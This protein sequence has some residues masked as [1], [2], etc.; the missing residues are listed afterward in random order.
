MT[1]QKELVQN[2]TPEVTKSKK[3]KMVAFLL[4]F[5]SSF[6]VGV[7]SDGSNFSVALR[8]FRS[9]TCGFGT[10]AACF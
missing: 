2:K 10:T 9:F 5:V 7:L 8:A 1:Q 3:G 4:L 6:L